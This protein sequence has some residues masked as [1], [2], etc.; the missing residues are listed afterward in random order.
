ML[1]ATVLFLGLSLLSM[2]CTLQTAESL[3]EQA[4]DDTL[5]RS[6]DRGA[7]TDAPLPAERLATEVAGPIE[8]NRY[9]C[10]QDPTGLRCRPAVPSD[11]C[12]YAAYE[13]KAVACTVQGSACQ[14][15]W[16]CVR[17][18]GSDQS[19]ID[20][21][22]AADPGGALEWEALVAEQCQCMWAPSDQFCSMPFGDFGG[23]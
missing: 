21:C 14:A 9:W 18:V 15:F 5:D 22:V 2:G 17:N 10:P 20:A 6:D 8:Q 12:D 3:P 19:A 16:S 11:P 1:K 7:V 13:V 23:V 4:P